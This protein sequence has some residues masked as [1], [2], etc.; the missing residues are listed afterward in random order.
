MAKKKT[1]KKSKKKVVKKSSKRV[2]KKSSKPASSISVRPVSRRAGV[3]TGVKVISVLYYIAALLFLMGGLA[4]IIGSNALNSVL[5]TLGPLV[6]ILGSVAGIIFLALAVLF[7]FV[8]K[9]LWRGRNWA[10]VTVLVLSALGILSGLYAIALGDLTS[11]TGLVINLIIGGYLLL[12]R[13]VK[14]AFR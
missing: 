2:V 6:A 13:S 11:I 12:N 4:L 1:V 7:F 9:D 10:R 5:G 8:G 14:A 3:P